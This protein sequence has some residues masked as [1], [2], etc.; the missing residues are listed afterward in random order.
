MLGD[1]SR[2]DR[3]LSVPQ[4]RFTLKIISA[5]QNGGKLWNARKAFKDPTFVDHRMQMRKSV[6]DSQGCHACEMHGS[7]TSWKNAEKACRYGAVRI[8]DRKKTRLKGL[9]LPT[10]MPP[11]YGRSLISRGSRTGEDDLPKG[12]HLPHACTVPHENKCWKQLVVLD[13]ER[14]LDSRIDCR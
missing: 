8:L 5:R 10:R 7:R 6:R 13:V 3:C 4:P 9:A 1:V 2:A 11:Q 12:R 14:Q